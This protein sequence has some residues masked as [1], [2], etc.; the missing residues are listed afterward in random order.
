[1][2]A[3]QDSGAR[4]KKVTR[5]VKIAKNLDDAVVL[6]SD[7]RGITP[8]SFVNNILVQYF[9]W[10]QF[11]EKGSVFMALDRRLLAALVEEV[12]EETSTDLARSVALMT[13]REFIKARFGKLDLASVLSFLELL[14]ARMNWGEITTVMGAGGALEVTAT[15][16]L[17]ARW[18]LFLSEFIASLLS[19]FLGMQT[20]SESSTYGCSVNATPGQD[21]PRSAAGKP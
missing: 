2:D 7:K 16:D 8:S 19:A 10:W 21:R 1:M 9:D 13:S 14:G 15:H 6:Q 12:S 4:A 5:A 18:S 17:G 20:V 3:R 11:A